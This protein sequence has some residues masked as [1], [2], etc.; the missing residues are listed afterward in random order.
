MKERDVAAKVARLAGEELMDRL[1][2]NGDTSIHEKDFGETVTNFDREINSFIIEE[3]QDHFPKH[4]MVTEEADEIDSDSESERWFVDPIDGTN[5]FVRHIPMYCVSI[6]FEREGEMLA[7][8]I[9]DPLNKSLFEG[10]LEDGA[11]LGKHKLQVS[12]ITDIRN[13][14]VF[15]GYGYDP[16]YKKRHEEVLEGLSEQAKYRR[17]LGTA[18]LMLAYVAQGMADGLILTGI[19]AWDCAAGA[20]LVRAA[21]GKVT[22]YEGDEW[23]PADDLIIAS[24]GHIHDALLKVAKE[25]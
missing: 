17:N 1:T 25:V 24:N 12:D 14:M 6:G 21:G 4:D 9:Y 15:E 3:L 20:T 22:N 7:G 13:A 5:N 11:F 19:K 16:E 8:A 10:S 18:A 23:T 2:K